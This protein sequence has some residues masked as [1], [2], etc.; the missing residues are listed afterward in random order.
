MCFFSLVHADQGYVI[1]VYGISL[2]CCLDDD[3]AY[4]IERVEFAVGLDIKSLLSQIHATPGYIDIVCLY[5]ID[6]LV[7]SDAIGC[8]LVELQGDL[9][10]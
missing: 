5:D 6:D 8:H 1:E 7:E 10:G 9:E 3:G 4:L 2:W